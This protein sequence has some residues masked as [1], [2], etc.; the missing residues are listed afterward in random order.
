MYSP[1]YILR[2]LTN[3]PVISPIKTKFSWE[4]LPNDFSKSTLKLRH[5][6]SV[7]L[8][9]ILV[10]LFSLIRLEADPVTPLVTPGII[11]AQE[12][13]E[14]ETK[15]GPVLGFGLPSTENGESTGL[16]PL[17]DFSVLPGDPNTLP[18]DFMDLLIAADPTLL[19]DDLFADIPKELLE[20]TDDP[21]TED[22]M[23]A[24]GFPSLPG[25]PA[26]GGAFSPS[27]T[28]GWLNGFS[29]APGNFPIGGGLLDTLREGFSINAAITGTYDTN[30]SQGFGTAA[31]SGQGDFFTTLGGTVAYRSIASTW[32]YGVNYSGSYSHYFD[33]TNL[34][35][36]NQNAGALLNYE[37]GPL[38]AGLNL[39]I[40]YGSGANRFH[41]AVVDQTSY[42]YGLFASYRISGKTSIRSNISQLI[43]ES[44]GGSGTSSLDLSAS[45]LWHYS[46]LTEF[47]PGIRYTQRSGDSQQ[48]RTS[49]G[50]TLAVNYQLAKKVSLNSTVGMDFVSFE[51]GDTPDP[52]LFTSI[53][54]NYRASSLWGMSLSLL[55]DAQ[56]SYS[57]PNEFEEVTSL[58]I[59]YNRRIRR[60]SWTLGMG[61]ETRSFE[62]PD[63]LAPDRPDNNYLTLDTSLSMPLFRGTTDASVFMRYQDQSGGGTRSWDSLQF[64]FGINRRF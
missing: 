64:G 19:D 45:A 58:R 16:L 32:T 1:F 2:R 56:A 50:P 23:P 20:S 37:G 9:G 27:I 12:S 29:N 40:D 44:S 63:S 18:D 5:R 15:P 6:F 26:G 62:N 38:T 43:S 3:F 46:P 54:L 49:I 35:G 13:P 53:G 31:D 28:G 41:A 36:Y 59:G 24:N 33:Q 51:N 39:G 17:K 10:M 11:P 21:V 57:N 61:W 47:G 48:E 60:A 7:V 22:S 4:L 52:S 34:S 55:R 25:M 42:N 30:P 8:S 14:N